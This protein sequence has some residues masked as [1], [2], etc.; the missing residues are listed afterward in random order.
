MLT[1]LEGPEVM[2]PLLK[3]DNKPPHREKR[4]LY[5]GVKSAHIWQAKLPANIRKGTHVIYIQTTDMFGQTFTG[6]RIIR[7][8]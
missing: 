5:G 2:K 4:L 1:F 3:E 7:V 8:R 6:H